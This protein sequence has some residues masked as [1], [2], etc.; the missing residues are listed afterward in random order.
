MNATQDIVCS[1]TGE[2]TETTWTETEARFQCAK[3]ALLDIQQ[4]HCDAADELLLARAQMRQMLE[5]FFPGSEEIHRPPVLKLRLEILEIR[6]DC[7]R[8]AA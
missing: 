6:D 1:C 3:R 7:N 8:A 2:W 4:Q 5:A